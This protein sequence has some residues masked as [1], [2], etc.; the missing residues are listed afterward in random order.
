MAETQG[1]L[2]RLIILGAGASVECGFYPT[3][4]QFVEVVR[5]IL[6][7]KNN[8][9]QTFL[10]SRELAFMQNLL[11][12][13]HSSIDAHISYINDKEE[14]AFLKSLIISIIAASTAYS[15]L[16]KNFEK[17]WYHELAKLIFSTV[18]VDDPDEER[19]ASIAKNLKFLQIITFNY[20][21]SLEL[22][23]LERAQH[24]FQKTDSDILKKF[25][26]K[27][28]SKIYHVYG[29]VA[30]GEDEI[31]EVL[32][33]QQSLIFSGLVNS[34]K[35]AF[36]DVASSKVLLRNNSKARYGSVEGSFGPQEEKLFPRAEAEK[37]KNYGEIQELNRNFI[38][39][40]EERHFSTFKD[41]LKVFDE[42]SDPKEWE[43]R[44]AKGLL[45]RIFDD[46]LKIKRENFLQLLDRVKVI[47]EDRAKDSKN[48]NED[49]KLNEITKAG[50][51][52]LYV[53]GYGFDPLNNE[54]L[55]L[56]KLKWNRGCF[57][58]NFLGNQKLERW[59]LDDLLSRNVTEG[60]TGNNKFKRYLIPSTSDKSVSNALKED[61]SLLENPIQP[62]EIQTNLAPYFELKKM[63]TPLQ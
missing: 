63:H 29:S 45:G 43:Q 3:G 12:S 54:R 60:I 4:A 55:R 11:N 25:L 47:N 14:K 10:K 37:L 50:C 17:N 49:Q 53:L 16:H 39:V 1:R 62:I 44:H 59:I 27:I 34:W 51:D 61:F 20:D 28:L 40:K 26:Q 23:L 19:L 58:T 24:F 13:N 7:H 22:Y 21:I 33:S 42:K 15:A 2:S 48:S 38:D 57:V 30:A 31:I 35:S 5:R 52:V 46:A 56:K 41:F 18:S 32:K 36:Y 6:D 9:D 8:G